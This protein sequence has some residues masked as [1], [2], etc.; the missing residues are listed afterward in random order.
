MDSPLLTFI[1]IAIDIHQQYPCIKY[2]M[3]T[4]LEDL[5][6]RVG[7]YQILCRRMNVEGR[8]TRPHLCLISRRK[9]GSINSG[10]GK[11]FVAQD[12]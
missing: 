11:R 7:M 2:E 1:W 10:Q 3:E 6:P 5:H 9:G 4:A 8:E 12:G